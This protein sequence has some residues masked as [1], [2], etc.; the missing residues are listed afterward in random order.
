MM[1]HNL[2]LNITK[3]GKEDSSLIRAHSDPHIDPIS[4][5]NNYMQ[6]EITVDG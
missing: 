3:Y 4:R 5:Q 2:F 6:R 1:D